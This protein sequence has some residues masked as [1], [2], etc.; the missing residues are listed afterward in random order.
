MSN[1]T[2]GE[3]SKIVIKFT[4][5][6]IGD[7]SGLTPTPIGGLVETELSKNR[8]FFGQKYTASTTYLTQTP[9][10]AFD[11]S[12]STFWETRTA[13]TQWIQCELTEAIAVTKFRLYSGGTNRIRAYN[14]QGSNNLTDWT[15]LWTGENPNL[16]QW[17]EYTFTN[18]T[19]YKYFRWNVT[20]RWST[21]IY[22][23]EL[24]L[25]ANLPVGNERAFTITATEPESINVSNAELS[26][27]VNSDIQ[28]IST[29][30][31][32]PEVFYD[33][34]FDGELNNV[35]VIGD[36][37]MLL[38]ENISEDIIL[39]SGT[40][41]I[42][43]RSNRDYGDDIVINQN[44]TVTHI[45]MDGTLNNGVSYKFFIEARNNRSTVLASKTFTKVGTETKVHKIAL[46][47]P[48][49]LSENDNVVVGF[50][51]S[52]S[53]GVKFLTPSSASEYV[54][55]HS[56]GVFNTSFNGAWS[57]STFSFGM[58]FTV[59]ETSY[60]TNGTYISNPY[61][62]STLERSLRIHWTEN[63]PTNT[64]VIVETGITDSIVSTPL[65]WESQVS[66]EVINNIPSDITNKY[67]WIKLT[68]STSNQE[69]TPSISNLYL[70]DGIPPQNLLLLN[71]KPLKRF[72]N[73]EGNITISYNAT[74]GN[75]QGLGG[76]V[77]SFTQV[78]T[79]ADLV[80]V[81]NPLCIENI[82]SDIVDYVVALNPIIDKVIGDGDHPT[83]DDRFNNYTVYKWEEENIKANITD[84]TIVLTYTAG[85]DP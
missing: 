14:L 5:N 81:P 47:T 68:L 10:L 33:E 31:R 8:D 71:T 60:L 46:D 52:G 50:G 39:Y 6:L 36:E 29:E 49:Q 45:T 44:I 42:N 43:D 82:K 17:N 35:E 69:A 34:E 21:N 32:P 26:E 85:I 78:F 22:I 64:D 61:V 30:M 40:S 65:S 15:E 53:F 70:E 74:L 4:Q 2:K 54:K 63:K 3:G 1:F 58:G 62:L 66:G 56:G 76:V 18:T 84:Y 79:P 20:S 7:V 19:A 9:N 41:T 38:T 67:L 16:T 24:E 57:T 27:L 48:L 83:T 28:I 37:L 11:N 55:T 13:G 23:Y 59:S 72:H 51:T 77:Q 80:R 73:T 12:T 25:F 75:L